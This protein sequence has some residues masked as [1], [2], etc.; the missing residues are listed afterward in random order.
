MAEKKNKQKNTKRIHGRKISAGKTALIV[1]GAIVALIAIAALIITI[2]FPWIWRTGAIFFG[3][4]DDFTPEQNTNTN[5]PAI[6]DDINGNEDEP[7]NVPVS[8]PHSGTK[9]RAAGVYNFLLLG[10]DKVALNTDVIMIMNFDVNEGSINIMQ[11]PRDTYAEF[12][13][14]PNK[15]NGALAQFYVNAR[16]AGE[17]DPWNKALADLSDFIG[18]AFD[19]PIDRYAIIDLEAFENIVDI[20]GG[21]PINVAED[22]H[23]DDQY[24]NLHIHINKG[25]NVLDGKTAAGFV[26]FRSGYIQ[27]DIGRQNAQKMFLTALFKQIKAEFSVSNV[28]QLAE[29]IVEK[30]T[31]NMSIEDAAYFA[32]EMLKVNLD[33]INMLTVPGEGIM[34]DLSY[35]VMYKSSVVDVIN[36]YLNGYEGDISES[37]FDRQSLFTAGEG[38]AVDAIYKRV[39]DGYVVNNGENID[40]D[41]I[42]I[43]R[44]NGYAVSN[45]TKSNE[46]TVSQ[47]EQTT[48]DSE[49]EDEPVTEEVTV[50]D[51]IETDT[52]E[53]ETIEIETFDEEDTEVSDTVDKSV[54]DTEEVELDF[55]EVETS[56]AATDDGAQATD[57]VDTEEA[58]EYDGTLTEEE[59]LAA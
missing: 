24:Q 58:E 3:F 57:G 12:G 2:K 44:V 33:S 35:Y 8:S 46:S 34:A 52:V 40:Q 48:K 32:R 43:P 21:V 7:G 45:T 17:K 28:V 53:S 54:S 55:T 6:T 31:T 26:R 11:L 4:D 59:I 18:G 39:V 29:E 16:N 19:V 25:Y 23:Y 1:I 22:M 10:R 27:A 9:K 56:E 41:G 38:T 50:T 5:L 15:I 13:G 36:T 37:D 20:I 30:T 14:Y 49:Y 42:Y 47:N 51:E